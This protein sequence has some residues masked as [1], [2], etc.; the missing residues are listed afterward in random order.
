MSKIVDIVG[1]AVFD[2]N[3]KPAVEAEVVLENGTRGRA[4]AP[5]GSTTGEHEAIVLEDSQ[6]LPSLSAAT[7]ALNV[8]R[9][10]IRPALNG[11]DG[12]DQAAIDAAL[13]RVDSSPRKERVGGNVSIA[14][15]MAA[16][17]AGAA[18]AGIPLHR[19]LANGHGGK[20][21]PGPMFNIIDGATTA[22]SA[23]AGIE[24]LLIP[25]RSL[26]LPS[27]LEMGVRVYGEARRELRAKGMAVG[28]SA[29]GA[30]E[31]QLRDCEEGFDVVLAAALSA[32]FRVGDDFTIGVDLA[33]ADY[34]DDGRYVFP[35]C[36][37]AEQAWDKLIERYE[38]WQ[39]VYPLTYLEDAFAESDTPAWVELTRRAGPTTEVIGD[40]LFAS[41][42]V[43]ITEGIRERWAHGVLIKPNQI[44][45]VT[46]TLR[47]M[48]I[49]QDS[50]FA[51]MVSQR[52]G[53]NDDAFITHLAVAGGARYLKAGGMSRM[54]RIIKFNELLRIAEYF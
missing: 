43:R 45:T 7:P 5:R 4:I 33:A 10:T 42:P 51:S 39:Q 36:T 31:G 47:S 30:V 48:R 49:A 17:K 2:S 40:D 6:K 8:I 15:S 12:R 24:F 53:E 37:P 19:H 11:V 9:E 27:A 38:R 29:Q 13:L 44:G 1:R 14:V 21:L 22:D 35:W 32:G 25:S 20:Q 3:G 46:E 52:S 54:D 34:Y 28:D 16:A 23:V 26:P 18:A 50:G 41:S